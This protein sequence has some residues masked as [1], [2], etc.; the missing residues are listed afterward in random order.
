MGDAG[1]VRISGRLRDSVTQHLCATGSACHSK[2]L[3]VVINSESD[4]ANGPLCGGF[5]SL[6]K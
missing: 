4:R 3:L 5:I 2:S 1:N 6:S